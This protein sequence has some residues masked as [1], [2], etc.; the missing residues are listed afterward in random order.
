[1]S[2]EPLVAPPLRRCVAAFPAIE[3]SLNRS[4]FELGIS[5]RPCCQHCQ[6]STNAKKALHDRADGEVLQAGG[7]PAKRAHK[8]GLTHLD[9][10]EDEEG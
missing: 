10:E 5:L 9:E 2:P 7:Q 1:M 4:E 8:V 3:E 6:P